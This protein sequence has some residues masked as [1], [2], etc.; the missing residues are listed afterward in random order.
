MTPITAGE[1]KV[2]FET[3]LSEVAFE[4]RGTSRLK[5]MERH[6]QIV[7]MHYGIGQAEQTITEIGQHFYVRDERMKHQLHQARRMYTRYYEAKANEE[8]TL[9]R[10][11]RLG[12][13]ILD[14]M[15]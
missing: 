5:W 12:E 6:Q 14:S 13:E 3:F 11:Q 8:A 10:R 7:C 1:W 4:K 2:R 15:K 9:L